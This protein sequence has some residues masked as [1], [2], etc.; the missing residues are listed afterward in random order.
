M[1]ADVICE[2]P[3]VLNP[4]NI[5]AIV[6]IEKE[7]QKNVYCILQ[8][9]LHEAIIAL[10]QK[11]DA[12]PVGTV[13]TV[14]LNYITTRGNWYHASWKGDVEKSGGIATNIGVHFFDML[15]WIFGPMQQSTVSVHNATT[16]AGTLTLQKANVTWSL[17]IDENSLPPEAIAQGKRTHRTLKID[18]SE[19]EF[20]EG[21][22]ELHTISY[23]HILNGNG[24]RVG[25]TKPAIELVH[26]IRNT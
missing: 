16:A 14:K 15:L 23:Q 21:F 6:D 10:K 22:T 12:S 8:L 5:D 9:R 3:I 20:S 4:W 7:T 17:S 2:K 13:H 25:I 19:F 24:F 18:G 26:S 1:G 11:I